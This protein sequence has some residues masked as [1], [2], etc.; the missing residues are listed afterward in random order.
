M[1]P[2]LNNFLRV[3]ALVGSIYFICEL[4]ILQ[5]VTSLMLNNRGYD[6]VE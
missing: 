6:F 4:K 1:K 5:L 2:I 3:R